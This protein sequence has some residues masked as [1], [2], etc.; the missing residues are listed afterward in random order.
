[1]LTET[2]SV[3]PITS[4]LAIRQLLKQLPQPLHGLGLGC[5]YPSAL[6][7]SI[8]PVKTAEVFAAPD[9]AQFPR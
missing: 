1:M 3:S 9:S 5:F 2:E 8:H 7:E 4:E 6:S